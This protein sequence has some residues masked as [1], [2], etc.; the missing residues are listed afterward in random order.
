MLHGSG[1][2]A[3]GWS[4]FKANFAALGEHFRVIAPDMPGW[5]ESDPV[6]LRSATTRKA[7]L[8]FMDALGIERATFVGNSMGGITSLRLAA[9]YPERVAT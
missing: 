2:G 9:E 3:T 1:P 5:G 7:A 8:D 6:T 4:N